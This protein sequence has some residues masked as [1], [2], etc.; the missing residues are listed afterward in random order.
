MQTMSLKENFDLSHHFNW[1]CYF[2]FKEYFISHIYIPRGAP[3]ISI[4]D[5]FLNYHMMLASKI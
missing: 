3:Q 5:Y 1:V 4:V 2:I